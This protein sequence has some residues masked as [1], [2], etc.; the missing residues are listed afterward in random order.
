MAM[1]S[2]SS[3]VAAIARTIGGKPER[4]AIDAG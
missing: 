4:D 3:V 2:E 1:A